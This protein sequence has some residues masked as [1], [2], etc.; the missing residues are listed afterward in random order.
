MAIPDPAELE[1][2]YQTRLARTLEMMEERKRLA[3]DIA[4]ITGERELTDEE[5]YQQRL[6]QTIR[7]LEEKKRLQQDLEAHEARVSPPL[8]AQ[9]TYEQRVQSALQAEQEQKKFQADVQARR[10]ESGMVLSRRQEIDQQ[11]EREEEG[12][13]RHTAYTARKKELGIEEDTGEGRAL[14]SAVLGR[15]AGLALSQT[16]LGKGISKI[17]GPLLVVEEAAN[18]VGQ[19]LRGAAFAMDV[20]GDSSRS[21]EQKMQALARSLPIIGSL[22]DGWI[23]FVESLD[24]TTDKLRRNAERLQVFEAVRG[25]QASY[26]SKKSAARF[27]LVRAEHRATALGN[28]SAPEQGETA[29]ETNLQEIAYKQ[30]RQLQP[31]RDRL[32]E[33]QAEADAA[34]ATKDFADRDVQRYEGWLKRHQ[35]TRRANR[36]H[37]I[38]LQGQTGEDP[39]DSRKAKI[40]TALRKQQ[41]THVNISAVEG[42]LEEARLRQRQAAVTLAEKESAIRKDGL[43]ISQR[44]LQFAEQREQRLAGQAQ[45][46][47]AANEVD[48]AL[49]LQAAKQLKEK[50]YESLIPEQRESFE[51]LYGPGALGKHAQAAAEREPGFKAFQQ[52]GADV[53]GPVGGAADRAAARIGH[54]A[55]RGQEGDRCRGDRGAGGEATRSVRPRIADRSGDSAAG[56]C[57][58]DG[59]QAGSIERGKASVDRAA[60]AAQSAMSGGR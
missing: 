59:D 29:R 3:A 25:V 50:G 24:G 13:K 48:R 17:A 23:R 19:G 52:A 42:H 46:Y 43:E 36:E 37:I 38:A 39:L 44:E 47:G 34:R 54:H 16:G 5:Q 32:Q 26:E 20:L 41:E 27:E 53:R 14:L 45:R 6:T 28:L 30:S 31:L 51:K 22:A 21:P 35:D 10:Q 57:D 40:D 60:G 33:S 49:A 56:G 55:G 1:A 9:Q 11:I 15:K 18:K 8:S 7:G 58:P 4:R 12:K 2:R